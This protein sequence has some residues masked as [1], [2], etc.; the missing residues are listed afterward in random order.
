MSIKVTIDY[1]YIHRVDNPATFIDVEL[2]GL[3]EYTNR[4]GRI[5]VLAGGRRRSIFTPGHD[6]MLEIKCEQVTRAHT[7]IIRALASEGA[8]LFFREPR[9]RI[10]WGHIMNP[11]IEETAIVDQ[12]TITFS[13]QQVTYSEAV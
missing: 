6:T 13:V 5:E 7:D 4:A 12:T 3:N 8:F 10:V 2:D 11:A 1:L 9:G